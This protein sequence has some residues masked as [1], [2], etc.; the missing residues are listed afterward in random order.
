M[1]VCELFGLKSNSI[2]DK[3]REVY[4]GVEYEI[5]NIV[6]FTGEIHNEFAIITD[7]SLR[8]NGR[9]FVTFPTSYKKQLFLFDLLHDPVNLYLGPKPYT[10]RT[11]IHVHV[12]CRNLETVVVKNIIRAYILTE[13]LFFR[14]VGPTRE[15]SIFC[16]PLYNTLLNH[17]YNEKLSVM[18]QNWHKYTAF[19]LLRLMDLGTI[20]FR[21]LYGTGD[22]DV[23]TSW[24]TEIN[25]L[26]NFFIEKGP[27]YPFFNE[28]TTN[29]LGLIRQTLPNFSVKYS[30]SELLELT[31]DS[32]LDLL[33]GHV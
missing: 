6:D 5:E 27:T 10:H 23:F 18:G 20:E 31:D 32:Y 21:H 22:K 9:E 30:D 25:L 2:L 8:N 7:G 19:N 13:R 11:S 16:V 26:F 33:Q 12:N 28:I 29:R 4:Y 15:N 3:A 24:L 1:K 14:F 17:L